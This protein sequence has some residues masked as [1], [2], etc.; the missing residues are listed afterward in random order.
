MDNIEARL[1]SRE[2]YCVGSFNAMASPCQLLVDTTD[3]KLAGK[4]LSIAQQEARRIEHK[5]SRYRNDNIIYRINN[6][7]NKPVKV[8]EETAALL[9]YAKHC[10]DIS[11]GSFDITSGV[12]REAWRFDG[13]NNIPTKKILNNLLPRIGWQNLTW[14][15]PYITVPKKME[16]DLGGIGKEYAVDKTSLLLGDYSISILVNYGGDLFANGVRKSGQSW[17]VGIESTN[18]LA[19]NNSKELDSH[20]VKEFNLERGG[21]ATS[22]DTRRF[23]IKNG[24]R[25]SHILDPRTG[26]PLLDAPHSVTVVASSCTDAGIIATLAM[27]KGEDAEEFLDSQNVKYWCQR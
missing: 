21:I 2:D 19:S 27:L 11:N 13:K 25:Y 7:N 14:E 6:S 20:S 5:F 23:L 12:L 8:D 18:K 10:Y 15:R 1:E 3:K 24:I 22:G 9:D 26:W 17:I 16:I 4:L